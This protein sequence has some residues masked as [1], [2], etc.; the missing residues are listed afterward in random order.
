MSAANRLAGCL[1]SSRASVLRLGAGPIA[2]PGT[3]VQRL[4]LILVIPCVSF[5]TTAMRPTAFDADG[6]RMLAGRRCTTV[7][8]AQD[9]RFS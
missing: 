2:S 1:D 3:R 4:M 7:S 5:L 6:R 9:W 8:G